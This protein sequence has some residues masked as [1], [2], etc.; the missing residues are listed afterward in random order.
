MESP[1]LYKRLGGYDALA[2]VTDDFIAR[3]AGDKTLQRFPGIAKI[4]FSASA[5]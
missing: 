4:P 3:L 2:A 1:S 5:N